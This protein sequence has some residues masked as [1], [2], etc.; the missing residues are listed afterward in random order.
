MIIGINNIFT[1]FWFLLMIGIGLKL[2]TFL[3]RFGSIDFWIAKFWLI[4]LI[5]IVIG[6]LGFFLIKF[7]FLIINKKRII[8]IY[9][10]RLKIST[11]DKIDIKGIKWYNV[12]QKAT[13]H[14]CMEIF[15]TKKN[16]IKFSDFEFENFYTIESKIWDKKE[17][18]S[19]RDNMIIEQTKNNIGYSKFLT[20]ILF[21]LSIIILGLMIKDSSYFGL[22]ISMLCLSLILLFTSARKTLKYIKIKKYG[23]Q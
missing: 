20:L 15:D 22:R 16:V 9:P 13:L 8:S 5:I 18:N 23:V 21:G 3:P 1:S 2:T 7:R 6:V 11:I 14:K 10:F 17:R 12:E 19:E 4:I